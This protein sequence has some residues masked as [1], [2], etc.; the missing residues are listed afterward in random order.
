LP[1][2]AEAES[3]SSTTFAVAGYAAVLLAIGALNYSLAQ[4]R[5]EVI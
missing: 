5:Q 4:E 3:D 1:K 2:T